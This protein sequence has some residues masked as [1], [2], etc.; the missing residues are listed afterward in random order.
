M[1]DKLSNSNQGGT[2]EYIGKKTKGN[3]ECSYCFRSSISVGRNLFNL[4]DEAEPEIVITDCETCR[5][6]IEMNTRYKVLHPVTVLFM[7]MDP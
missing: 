5:M 7:A 1:Y 2:D 3:L 4:I 6:Q